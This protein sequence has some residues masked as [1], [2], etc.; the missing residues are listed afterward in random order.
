MRPF[1]AGMKRFKNLFV[2]LIGNAAT[3][4]TENQFEFV[5]IRTT[6]PNRQHARPID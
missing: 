3:I 2:Q 1:S 4:I 5:V 6:D